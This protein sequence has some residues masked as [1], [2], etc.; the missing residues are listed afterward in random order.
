M[1][2]AA[3]PF[4]FR[5]ALPLEDCPDDFD[6]DIWDQIEFPIYAIRSDVLDV[7]DGWSVSNDP[8]NPADLLLQVKYARRPNHS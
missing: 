8:V 3:D 4:L 6:F 2:P 1:Y 5:L 7:K